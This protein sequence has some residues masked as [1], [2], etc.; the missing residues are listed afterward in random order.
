WDLATAR[1]LRKIPGPGRDFRSLTVSPDGRR[2]AA[3]ADG[4]QLR[5]CDLRSGE[6]LFAD[7]GRSL[8]YSPD[9]RWLAV[10]WAGEE[11]TAVL[12]DA[13]THETVARFRGHEK[14]VHSAAFSPDSRRLASCSQD[15]TVRLWQV[16]S[17]ACQ[18]LPG[19]TGE[20]LAAAF[21]SDGTRLATAG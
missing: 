20:I 12:L 15:H 13:Q 8:A 11:N 1:V 17:G 19:H 6:Q 21:H 10:V 3:W 14:L 16:D 2:V 9:G 5:V 4:P 7:A 18:E